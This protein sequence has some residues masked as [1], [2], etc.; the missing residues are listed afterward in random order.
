MRIYCQKC[1]Q[2]TEYSLHGGKPKFCSHC[3]ESFGTANYHLDAS[4]EKPILPKDTRAFLDLEEDSHYD[5]SNISKLEVD[6][7]TTREKSNTVTIGDL[8]GSQSM[9]NPDEPR[10]PDPEMSSEEFLESFRKEAGTLRRK[11]PNDD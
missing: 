9:I 5:G 10:L 1:G 2:P 6:I 11:G 8:A 7:D 3:A 4:I